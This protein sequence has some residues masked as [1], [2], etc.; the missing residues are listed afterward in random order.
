MTP[1]ILIR[2]GES[3][4]VEFKGEEG[5]PLSDRDLVEACVCLANHTG[6]GHSWLIVGV[7][8]D[9][10]VTGAHLPHQAGTTDSHR[11]QAK[12]PCGGNRKGNEIPV[13]RL[14]MRSRAK[15]LR[16]RSQM[17]SRSDAT[18]CNNKTYGHS[19]IE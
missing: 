5:G 17:S 1:E 7:E 9:G 13:D 4:R 14:K 18:S 2:Q 6:E 19:S 10:R 16:S 11:V 3:L 12:T 8:D 15:H